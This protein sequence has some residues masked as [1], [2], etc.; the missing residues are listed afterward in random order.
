MSLS[1]NGRYPWMTDH[2]LNMKKLYAK[3][4]IDEKSL[5]AAKYDPGGFT[6]LMKEKIE[7]MQRQ[8][9]L[10]ANRYLFADPGVGRVGFTAYDYGGLWAVFDN[11]GNFTKPKPKENRF[12]KFI[13]K[14]FGPSK[15]E[16]QRQLKAYSDGQIATNELLQKLVADVKGHFPKFG[17]P[18]TR[19]D[20]KDL[21]DQVSKLGSQNKSLHALLKAKLTWYD[22]EVLSINVL[23][24]EISLQKIPE[25]R[26][27]AQTKVIVKKVRR[28]K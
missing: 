27:P 24:N 12:M 7:Q 22:S 2:D 4:E 15:K 10:D 16:L 18:D 5:R 11:F 8:H 26:I 19:R 1:I 25:T 14:L 17:Y 23:G 3:A 21:Q 28:V 6:E 13:K 20:I 9:Q